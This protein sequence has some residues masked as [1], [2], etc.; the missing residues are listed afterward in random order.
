VTPETFP[1]RAGIAL[2]YRWPWLVGYAYGK[3]RSDPAYR[4]VFRLIGGGS[5]P[6]LDLGCG[7]GILAFYLR[8]RG[9]RPAVTGLDLD[10]A[11]IRRASR[12]AARHY[13]DMGFHCRDCADLPLFSGDVVMLDVLHYLPPDRQ[14]Q[15]LRAMA[16]RVAPGGWC[17]VRVSPHGAGWRF[18]CTLWV[19]ALAQR[20]R[21]MT[22]QPVAFPTLADISRQFPP[23]QFSRDIRPLWGLTPFNSWLLAFR[24][25]P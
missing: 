12:I 15:V 21:W 14:G 4:E 17:I 8:E 7:M 16:E 9:F 11:K 18:R 23:S 24:R 6:L 1:L 19:E 2:R 22:P 5:R 25:L 3:M 13:P 10:R 20:L